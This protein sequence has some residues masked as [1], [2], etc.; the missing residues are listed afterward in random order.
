MPRM[1]KP[2]KVDLKKVAK[3]VDLKKVAK[4]V[5]DVAERVE[6]TSDDVR[7]VSAQAKRVT[8]RMS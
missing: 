6:Q 7:L 3:Q 8:R 4:Q 1:T 2:G 5:G